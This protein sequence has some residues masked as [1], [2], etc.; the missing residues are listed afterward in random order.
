VGTKVKEKITFMGMPA[1][2]EWTVTEWEPPSAVAMDGVGPMGTTMKIV[3]RTESVGDATRV[4][5]ESRFGGAALTPM[6][7]VIEK[8]ARKA[9]AA[10]LEKL[11]A[12]LGLAPQEGPAG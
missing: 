10:S 9:S 11:R 5:H 2:V 12:V 1:D 3:A 8:E 4:T 7:G 6:L